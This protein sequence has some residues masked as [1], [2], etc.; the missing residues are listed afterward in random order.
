MKKLL[1]IALFVLG[2]CSAPLF[3]MVQEIILTE[4]YS[5]MPLDNPG[6][7][8]DGESPNPNRFHATIDGHQLL[9]DSDTHEPI[10]IEIVSKKS[11][12][13]VAA[14]E[15]VGSTAIHV[16]RSGAYTLQL[17]SGNSVFAGEFVVE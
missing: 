5:I 11:G 7:D 17:Y 15:F 2:I 13:V 3:G 12:E 6:T 16:S 14:G 9:I 8:N 4:S 10:Y 1:I